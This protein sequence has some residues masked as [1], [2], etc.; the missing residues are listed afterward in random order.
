M[1]VEQLASKRVALFS[2][3]SGLASAMFSLRISEDA[4]PSSMLSSLVG[5]LQDIPSRLSA[6]REVEPRDFV[7]TL[8]WRE[9]THHI[10]DF[11]PIGS[12]ENLFPGTFFL[13]QVDGKFCRSYERKP[14][15]PTGE[16][17]INGEINGDACQF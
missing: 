14:R 3:G 16:K 10:K 5:S 17:H 13:A 11:S 12:T 2:Y 6:R 7:A 9:Q 1:P 15:H 4:G 8:N